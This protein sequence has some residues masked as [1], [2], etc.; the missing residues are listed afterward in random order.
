LI[1]LNQEIIGRLEGRKW[2]KMKKKVHMASTTR[3]NIYIERPQP[4][5]YNPYFRVFVRNIPRTVDSFQLQQFFSKYGKVATAKVMRKRKN[6]I[7]KIGIVTIAMVEELEDALAALD[8]LVGA[9][10]YVFN[11]T[12]SLVNKSHMCLTIKFGFHVF[13]N[14]SKC[15]MMDECLFLV[16]QVFNGCVLEV[17]LVRRWKGRRVFSSRPNQH[18]HDYLVYLRL[19]LLL[20]VITMVL[21]SPI[22]IL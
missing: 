13:D 16:M 1:L 18:S 3:S 21:W 19:L 5:C 4:P 2:W 22:K 9:C 17:R 12:S 14:F 6:K 20:F 7:R 11:L 15:V 10:I 8:G